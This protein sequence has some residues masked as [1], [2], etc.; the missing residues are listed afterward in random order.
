MC[1][2]ILTSCACED[3]KENL[4]IIILQ[5]EKMLLSLYSYAYI[6]TPTGKCGDVYTH[7]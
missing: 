6:Y 1:P 2:Y 3:A 4:N 7:N 5:S